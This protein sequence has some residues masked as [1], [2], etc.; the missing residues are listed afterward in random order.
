[1]R[2]PAL[3]QPHRHLR[4]KAHGTTEEVVTGELEGEVEG[5]AGVEAEEGMVIILIMKES[6]GLCAETSKR[7]TASTALSAISGTRIPLSSRT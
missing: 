4:E 6:L 1:M 7:D 3:L 2:A 5:E